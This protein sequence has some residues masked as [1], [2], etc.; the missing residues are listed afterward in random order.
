MTEAAGG[1]AAGWE[2]RLGWDGLE[3]SQARRAVGPVALCASALPG[4]AATLSEIL[5]QA[6]VKQERARWI[7]EETPLPFEDVL[8][9]FVAW[10]RSECERRAGAAH[11]RFATR[12]HAALERQLL[13]WLSV[14]AAPSLMLEFSL[15]LR[16]SGSAL[17]AWSGTEPSRAGYLDFAARLL[18]GGLV[19]FLEEYS[20]LAR[21]LATTA[22]QWVEVT[23]E[24]LK[25]TDADEGAVARML[26]VEELPR[27]EEVAPSLSDPHQGRRSVAVLTFA[28][29]ARVVYK[30]R[31]AGLEAGWNRLLL[32]LAT[33][34]APPLPRRFAVLE[35]GDY[36]WAEHVDSAP[37]EGKE[38]EQRYFA[39]AGALLCL[40]HLLRGTDCHAD[41]LIPAGEHPIL[42]DLE[43]LLAPVCVEAAV[44]VGSAAVR[45]AQ[46]RL[47]Q[48]VL[49]TYLLPS[50]SQGYDEKEW[51]DGSA[52]GADGEL[53]RILTW[54]S[55]TAINTDRMRLVRQRI[56]YQPRPRAAKADG[57]PLRVAEHEGELVA[58]F[59]AMYRFLMRER[60]ALLAGGSPF[61]RLK[62]ARVRFVIRNT[63]VYAAMLE[64]LRQPELLRDGADRS[65]AIEALARSGV[66]NETADGRGGWRLIWEAESEA[67]E[68][69]DVPHF[70]AMAGGRGLWVD[71]EVE[72]AD[73]FE[74]SGHDAS[75]DRLRGLNESDLRFQ[76]DLIRSSV[77][78]RDSVSSTQPKSP[79]SG[80]PPSRMTGAASTKRTGEE[81]LAEALSIAE[82]LAREAIRGSDGSAAW[83][84]PPWSRDRIADLQ[85]ERMLVG[86]D[87]YDGSIG[88]ALFLAAVEH[89]T[90]RSGC[91]QLALAAIHELLFDLENHG[92]ELADFLGVGGLSGL[93]SL[94]YGLTW[95]HRL[96]EEP[97]LREGAD[98]A[99]ALIT[100]ERIE[101]D[102]TFDVTSG[103]AGALLGLLAL[104]E[105]TGSAAALAT[106]ICCGQRLASQ[107]EPAP[108]GAKGS[109]TLD[110]RFLCGFSH[111]AAGMAY[112]LAR[113]HTFTAEEEFLEA[114][115][116]LIGF[117]RCAFS[118]E[119]GDWPD[120]R[121]PDSP[122][123]MP[124]WCHGAPGIALGR[125]GGL[126]HLGDDESRAEIERAL[127]ITTRLEAGRDDFLCCGTMGVV[128]VLVTAGELLG[129]SDLRER[130]EHLAGQVVD[131]RRM[132][133]NYSLGSPSAGRLECRGL[134][135]GI[136]GIGHAMLRLAQ[137]AGLPEVLLLR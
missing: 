85:R 21:V 68:R 47:A 37:C 116:E 86:D 101:A 93:G 13:R 20:A 26:G 100:V 59:E 51:Y 72:V 1:D 56:V 69:G 90:G 62:D 35:R 28:G 96:L 2:R 76:I 84:Q 99:A 23:V 10:S 102:Q 27:I 53:E 7:E 11:R 17:D 113:L 61:Q 135:R 117:E 81:W 125:I 127:G 133:G 80:P 25:R 111:G 50:W 83:L 71:R 65:L 120:L 95:M 24:L 34:G 137:P 43:T 75:L 131:R 114:A 15:E 126:A 64:R 109:R 42:I 78:S 73:W 70:S 38:R 88:I 57:T 9:P 98:R 132:C 79:V 6:E 129:R 66:I 49:A 119:H 18:R 33:Q 46:Q 40:V 58:G 8:E 136:A 31:D 124:S 94:V 97:I 30:P 3:E 77:R 12:A 105:S 92:E 110:R 32:W 29:G 108:N 89:A 107:L 60:E 74:Q 134:F 82:G 22:T 118:V 4:W 121:Y 122:R 63:G 48:S 44:G 112:A 41:N 123:F 5:R 52:L 130:A 36:E 87:L 104:H 54:P 106:A 91:H 19:P 103:C 115:R 128:E 39:R 55:W 67:I 16:H 14:A 45:L